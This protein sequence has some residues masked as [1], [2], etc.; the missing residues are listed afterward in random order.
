LCSPCSVVV[1]QGLTSSTQ[2]CNM[3]RFCPDDY[4]EA[5]PEASM[6][7]TEA[8]ITHI[9]SLAKSAPQPLVHPIL[10][11]RF[12]IACTPELLTSL[13]GLA[14]S[15]PS[16]HIQ[17]HISENQSEIAFTRELFPECLSYADVYK[18]FGLLRE[19]TILA[20]AVHLEQ[21][22]VELIRKAKTGISH[23]PTSNFNLC[24]GVAKV[25]ELLDQG[26]KVRATPRPHE[27]GRT[28]L[29]L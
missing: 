23:C 17:T 24:S 25:G 7:A 21:D 16:L 10:T 9:R 8:L 12:A 14:A 13:G 11:P 29:R 26:I 22:E 15:D 3:D 5:S 2:K 6:Q 4:T 27:G 28:H 18:H 19:N 20:H 1:P